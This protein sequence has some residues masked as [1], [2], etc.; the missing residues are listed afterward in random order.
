MLSA[1]SLALAAPSFGG[2]PPIDG[3]GSFTCNHAKGSVTFDPPLT[4]GGTASTTVKVSADFS[5][6]SGSGDGATVTGGHVSGTLTGTPFGDCG[7]SVF[8][9]SGTLTTTF[10]VTSGS[11]PLDPSI[12]SF[13]SVQGSEG[14]SPQAGNVQGSLT[15]GSFVDDGLFLGFQFQSST[16]CLAKW[17][18]GGKGLNSSFEMG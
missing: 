17:K 16:S 4:K 14:P 1:G 13:N 2:S 12:S 9:T 3:G 7:F 18:I 5:K 8:E 10:K 11:P 15:S 6:C